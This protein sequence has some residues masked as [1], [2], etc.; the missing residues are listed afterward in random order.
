[1]RQHAMLI[2]TPFGKARKIFKNISR[3]GV[4]NMRAIFMN[5]QPIV[6]VMVISVSRDM[7]TFIDNENLFSCV[8]CQAFCKHTSSI[9]GTDYQII[10]HKTTP[11]GSLIA[12][13]L[14]DGG[15]FP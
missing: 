3:I 13:G 4:K 12:D 14:R 5:Q 1:P 6:I 8:C 15:G 7:R 9:A 11:S 10:E 2:S